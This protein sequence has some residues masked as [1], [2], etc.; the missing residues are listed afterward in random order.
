MKA[1]AYSQNLGIDHPDALIEIDLPMPEAKGFD[2]LVKVKAI[3]MNPVDYKIRQNKA[4]A[5]GESKVLGWDASGEVVAVGENVSNFAI[6]DRVFYAGDLNRQGTNTEYQL[7]DARLVG[8]APE[9]LSYLEAA[10][11]PLTA[12]TAWELLF[13][14][15]HLDNSAEANLLVIGAAGGVGSML[16]QLAKHMTCARVIASASRSETQQWVKALG[17]DDVIDH[18]K[19][20]KSQLKA[21][22]IENVSHVASLNGTEAVFNQLCDVT[23]AFGKIGLID[24]P[25][26]IDVHQLKPKSQSLHWE[27]MFAKSLHAPATMHSQGEL[28]NHVSELIEQGHIQS[29]SKQDY[30]AMSLKTLRK[31]HQDLESGTVIG[32]IVMSGM[33]S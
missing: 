32:K 18:S 5:A 7:V 1:I 33:H 24:D 10:A 31:A 28:L 26:N 25:K 6:G 13:E 12:I 22:G 14:H 23:Q 11:V 9:N 15:L 29:T 19:D 16:I 4:L 20:L 17:A 2:L 8:R 21:L 30:G 27:F 3:A